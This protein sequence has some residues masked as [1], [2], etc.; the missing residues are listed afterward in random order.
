MTDSGSPVRERPP[1]S[2]AIICFNEEDNIARCLDAVTWCDQIVAVDS[3]STDRTCDVIQQYPNTRLLQRPFD[4]FINQ[5]NHALAHC[6]HEWVVSVDAD[7]VL[8]AP[9]IAEIQELEF[10]VEGYYIARRSFLGDQEIK[11][12]TWSPDYQLRLFRKSCARWGGSNPHETVIL[13]GRTQRLSSRMLH[14]TYRNRQEFIERNRRYIRM[15]VEYMVKQGR[16][17]NFA[18][19]FTHWLGNFLKAYLL[20]AGFL[21][22]SAGLF[23]AYHIANGSFL[24]YRLLAKRLREQDAKSAED[25]EPKLQGVPRSP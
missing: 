11:H 7:E 19:P 21:D 17:T 14:Y 15:M 18:E 6:D 13:N 5:K 3:G 9:L 23:L 2:A 16:T 4:N 8:T 12:G 20:R 24:K 10:D 22:G 1:I 25:S